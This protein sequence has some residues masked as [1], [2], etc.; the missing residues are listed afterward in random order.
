MF[1]ACELSLN[2]GSNALNIDTPVRSISMD[3]SS[4]AANAAFPQPALA[5][6][7]PRDLLSKLRQLF[8]AGATRPL[9]SR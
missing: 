2:S 7:V 9:S 8:G 6:G 4:A 3:E 5:R 1:A